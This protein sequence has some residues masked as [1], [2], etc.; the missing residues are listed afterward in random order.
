MQVQMINAYSNGHRLASETARQLREAGDHE[1]SS[2]WQMTSRQ[3]FQARAFEMG[4]NDAVIPHGLSDALL[5]H[6]R[7]NDSRGTT[8]RVR[9]AVSDILT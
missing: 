1:L 4:I 5:A 9:L 3:W 8:D 7:I 6:E 2:A